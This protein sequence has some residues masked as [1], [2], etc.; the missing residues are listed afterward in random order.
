MPSLSLGGPLRTPHPRS[1]TN[2]VIF[3]FASSSARDV[4]ANT[5]KTS[6]KPPLV[7]QIFWPLQ[8]VAP[9]ALQIG[10]RLD[11]R[12]VAA[13]AHLGQREGRYA[14]AAREAR[15]VPALLLLGAE[16]NE[17]LRP[18]RLVSAERQRHARVE[19]RHLLNDPGV[20]RIREAH[21]PVALGNR[22]PEE[23]ELP[24]A[25][26]DIRGDLL[27]P[28]DLG[29]VDP[30]LEEPARAVEQGMEAV[31]LGALQLRPGE[32]Q[33]L[34]DVPEEQTLHQ[35]AL[36]HADLAP[37]HVFRGRGAIVRC[38]G[39][40]GLLALL[41][42]HYGR[43][44]DRGRAHPRAPGHRAGGRAA[45]PAPPRPPERAATKRIFGPNLGHGA[46]RAS[47]RAIGKQAGR[48]RGDER[49][50]SVRSIGQRPSVALR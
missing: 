37:W 35:R 47:V 17:P 8:H 48:C 46:A 16:E 20:A 36:A 21:A 39:R 28:I 4:R 15:Q 50:S 45:L 43:D 19:P 44:W 23:A 42:R 49:F 31:D 11:G 41:R 40:R 27:L 13:G 26:E 24:Q 7:I 14:L 29:G 34:V 33:T 1:T 38:P 5:V 12:G 25:H 3:G 6:A 2:A 10:A 22:Q 30:E 9:V 32:H 18:D